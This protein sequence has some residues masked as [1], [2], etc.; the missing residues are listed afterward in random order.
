MKKMMIIAVMMS[1]MLMPAQMFAKNDRGNAKPRVEN[2]QKRKEIKI[3]KD[4]GNKPNDRPNKNFQANKPNNKPKYRPGKPDYRPGRPAPVVVVN[5]PAPRPCPP[6][7]P[8][9]RPYYRCNEVADAVTTFLGI[10]GLMA[11]IAD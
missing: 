10:V 4:R 6:P 3:S 5:R 2:N 11:I 7:P 9:P 8:A 1:A